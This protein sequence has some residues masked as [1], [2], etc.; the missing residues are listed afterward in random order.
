MSANSQKQTFRRARRVRNFPNIRCEQPPLKKTFSWALAKPSLAVWGRAVRKPVPFGTP[1]RPPGVAW[2]PSAP[3][4]ASAGRFDGRG[5]V[6]CRTSGTVPNSP[7]RGIG[8]SS[9]AG[10]GN[11]LFN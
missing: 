4:E 1:I 11:I 2:L 6:L 3:R 5:G 10:Q 7:R 9:G 8:S